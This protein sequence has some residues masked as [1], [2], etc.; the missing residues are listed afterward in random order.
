MWATQSLVSNHLSVSSFRA[1]AGRQ[2]G[3]PFSWVVK[4][5]SGAVN[6]AAAKGGVVQGVGAVGA[7]AAVMDAVQGGAGGVGAAGAGSKGVGD[8]SPDAI[9]GKG[10]GCGGASCD[11]GSEEE[12]GR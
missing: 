1:Q 4:Q 9:E 7:G 12:V 8:V 11:V 10:S 5:G 2:A 6:V 3:S